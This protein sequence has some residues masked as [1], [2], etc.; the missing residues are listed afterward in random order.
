MKIIFL[1][2]GLA[3]IKRGMER[4]FLELAG[5][6]RKAG[7]DAVCWGTAEG[8]GVD[9]I[10]VPSRI[11]L[12][13]F[14]GEH[15][16]SIP[17]LPAPPAT[18]LQN[19]SF[20]TEDQLFAIPAAMR[21][22]KLL[23]EGETLLVY[24]RWQGGFVDASGAATILL[25]TLAE[26][27]RQKKAALL[28]HT[29][30]IYPPI[31]SMLWA[32]GAS[33][34][35]IGPWIG[36]S[37]RQ[38]GVLPDAIVELPM[39][40]DGRPYRRS[41]DHR[42][43]MRARL[44]IPADAFVILSVGVFDMEAKR[45]DYVLSEIQKLPTNNV[46]WVVAGSRGQ[47]S[48]AWEEDARRVLGSRF[49]P[50]L[51]VPF[52]DMPS[53][54]GAAD[55]F[56]SA[57]LYETFGLV[58]LEAQ[59]AALPA[60]VHDTPVTRHLFSQLPD[61]LKGA[62]LVDTRRQGATAAALSR[63]MALL[64]NPKD[65]EV[66]REALQAFGGSQ[67]RQFGWELMSVHYAAAFDRV[68]RGSG[69]AR[70]ERQSLGASDE[71]LHKQG[72]HLY[73]AGK[74]VEALEAVSKALGARETGERW[75]DW[76]TIQSAIG[77]PREAEQGFRRALALA[78]G[79][80]QATANLGLVLAAANRFEE[81]IP[82]LE[83]ALP[84]ADETLR[85]TLKQIVLGC[86]SKLA[87][88]QPS[89]DAEIA[90]F[91]KKQATRVAV[92]VSSGEGLLSRIAP[93]NGYAARRHENA[94]DS[95]A[96]GAAHSPSLRQYS[97]ED[98][99]YCQALIKEVP[100]ASSGQ[101]LLGIGP[102]GELLV[103]ALILLRGYQRVQWHKSSNQAGV[104]G[105]DSQFSVS[106]ASWP[107]ETASFD[108]VLFVQ[109]LETIADDPMQAMSEINRIL[110]P[111][112]LLFVTTANIA[113]ARS[114][115]ALLRGGT[116][117]VNGRFPAVPDGSGRQH[118][119][120]TCAEVEALVLAGGFGRI[121]TVTRDIFWKSPEAM[122]PSLAASG[123]SVS[124]RGDTIFM[125]ARKES[126]VRDRYPAKLYDLS[127][128]ESPREAG[129]GDSAT[130]RI[131]IIFETI[132]MPDGGGADHRLMQI[133]RLLREQ[134]HA[135]T[136]LAPRNTGNTMRAEALKEL[137]VEVRIDDAEVLRQEGIDVLPKWTPQ[138]VLREGQFDL[139]IVSL[140]FWMGVTL[141]EYYLD[142]IRRFSPNTRV[143]IL[144]DDCHGI[145]EA[146]GAEISGLW[147][148]KERAAD[149]AGRETDIYR[150]SDLVICISNSDKQKL[151]AEIGSVPAEVVPMMIEPGPAAPGFEAREG[152][153]YLGHFNNPPTLDGLE[154]YLREVAPLVRR[155]LP[156]LR[157][158]VLGRG[159]PDDWATTEPKVVRLGFKLDLGSEFAQRR[160][161]ISPV[162][163]GTGIKTK[164]LHALAHGLPI[165]TNT[166]GAEG[167][168][169]VSGETALIADD[170][171]EF[172][173]AVIKLY[174]DG[175]LW[176][177]LSGASRRHAQK[178]FS[179]ETMD[180]ALRSVLGRIRELRPQA[181]DPAHVWS[182]RRVEKM[183]LE[184]MNY[185]PGKHRQS[186]RVLAY[187]RAADQF[188]AEGNR[189]EARR[190]LR[191]VFNF[192]AHTMSR[193]I[194][195]SRFVSVAESM[196]KTYRALG[197]TEAAEEFRRE[198][199]H[200]SASAFSEIPP[201]RSVSLDPGPA[202]AAEPVVSGALS[203]ERQPRRKGKSQA[204]LD[205]SVIVPTHNRASV[206]A[207]CLQALDNQ[208]LSARRFE[209]IVVDDGSNDST[210][211][212]CAGH[213]PSHEF[214]YLH[215]ENAGA[216]AA[217]RLGV[218]KAR[219]KY[220]L[221]MNDDTIASR[222]LLAK[223][224]E[225]QRARASEKI[226][227]LGNFRYPDEAKRRALTWFLS[228]NPF[229]FPQVSLQ[230]GTYATNSF[231]ITCN[232]SVR[233]DLVLNAGSFDPNF[234]LSED[235]DLGIRLIQRG[236]RIAY[237]PEIAAIHQHLDFTIRD[238]IRRA[239]MYG[240][241]TDK[242]Y[243]KHPSLAEGRDPFAA[244]ST[245]NE[246]ADAV[247]S[248]AKFDSIDFAPYFSREMD[249][250]NAAEQVMKLFEYAVPTVYWH[251]FYRAHNSRVPTA[252]PT[253]KCD[254][255]ADFATHSADR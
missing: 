241:A 229:L 104:K 98:L 5:E 102:H 124:A 76:A 197:E 42:E 252:K 208:S 68:M 237:V 188:L 180:R 141:P 178:H 216:G 174:S 196:E 133:I 223:H 210:R 139:A 25:E 194:F 189:A 151:G 243:E 195:F 177:K 100:A 214:H 211:Q 163:F 182:M 116:P 250:K 254:I 62:S 168:E 67:Q 38:Q 183:F 106:Q 55:V 215:Q 90:A 164:N 33:F 44:C 63:W 37:L 119:E 115:H 202:N 234:R 43:A 114:L 181:Y 233:R 129:S 249:G 24:G 193:S 199:R 8:P 79:H 109:T 149:F 86:R 155:E 12:Q 36:A 165:V 245:E 103:Q 57:S 97:S 230:P 48:A 130:M 110:K 144:T 23:A 105:D 201:A 101:R 58:Y 2:P 4:F 112:G 235:T 41:R 239:E 91:L 253:V 18:A 220:L 187:S 157:L 99:L 107:F 148:D 236:L 159:L 72:V 221:L 111:G 95:G 96:E 54:Y 92:P 7:F 21:I 60:V 166:K 26:G 192:M 40:I 53:L 84:A 19:W 46:W 160:I 78:P 227:V 145:R 156:G 3:R 248:L 186:I 9:A 59:M 191:H 135:V 203:N 52:E 219:G 147:S 142:E 6:L 200:F 61:G 32:S 1:A 217:R 122:M 170:P 242:L 85:K 172:A 226:A 74:H 205:F 10:P 35:A 175:E 69:T 113:S 162:R 246:V 158:Y 39:C 131:L 150:R 213:D 47:S 70:G 94:T 66:T 88:Q 83:Q 93:G 15:L 123:F 29:D 240:K 132:P 171:R 87:T 30:Y 222:E 117:Y 120:Y 13:K 161:L 179:K 11:E 80:A 224:L 45:H 154:W 31:D 167:G 140:W 152:L 134:G 153:V 64:S 238:L 73:G 137:G 49:I 225:E 198:G 20:Y 50:V 176:K 81:A 255:R 126:G 244:Y 28:I 16:Q 136:F 22:K 218:E 125:R 77:K 206:L 17:G 138:E 127:M 82:L 128:R 228:T 34:H 27:I 65:R 51:D 204:N 14:A 212:L 108:V 169:F 89:D 184:V 251:H 71:Q 185:Q 56:A 232:I 207:E 143:A 173:D 121:Q 231:F 209:V 118:R 146:G 247:E 190:Q 75:N